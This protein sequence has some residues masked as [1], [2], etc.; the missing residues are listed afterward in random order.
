MHFFC[1]KSEFFRLFVIYTY[2]EQ[3]S[4]LSKTEYMK[5]AINIIKVIFQYSLVI[6]LAIYTISMLVGVPESGAE[7]F[8]WKLISSKLYAV[9]A[10]YVTYTLARA[11]N[12]LN[13][14]EEL[15]EEEVA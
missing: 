14:N 9:A 6:A 2:K 8:T 4:P 12:I 7:N 3:W 1:K 15:K 5:A 10:G 13:I 11:W